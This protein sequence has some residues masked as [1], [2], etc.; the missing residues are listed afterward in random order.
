MNA[1]DFDATAD[2]SSYNFIYEKLVESEDDINGMIAYSLYKR[3][4]IE[5]IRSFLSKFP[6]TAGLR[7][8]KSESL[9]IYLL[10]LML[11]SMPTEFKLA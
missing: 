10:I 8:K 2:D 4:K 9:F 1:S 3:E 11:G 6:S 7:P 5:F